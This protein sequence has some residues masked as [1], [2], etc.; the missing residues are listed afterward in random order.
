[1]SQEKVTQADHIDN[2]SAAMSTP[3]DNGSLNAADSL[4]HEGNVVYWKSFSFLGSLCAIMLMANSLFIGYS[5]PVNVLSVI[6]ADIGPSPNIYLVSMTF[7]LVSGVMLLIVGRLS[8][9]VGRR[10]FMM[11]AQV[12]SLVGSIIS[13]RANTVNVVIG[14]TVLSAFAGGAQQLYPMLVQELV[15]NKYRFYSQA[16]ITLSI[17]PTI[18]FGTAIARAFVAN[19]H[20]G[21]RWCY[22]LNVIV[23]GLSIVLLALCYFP[24]SFHMINKEMTTLQELRQ[25][26]YGG[27][28]LYSAGLVLLLLGFTW[29]EGTYPWSSAHVIAPIVVGAVLVAVFF[30]YQVYMPLKQPLM[31]IRLLKIRNF[32]AVVIVGC[33]GQMVY[34]ALNL[35][36][37]TIITTFLTTDNIKI[38]LMSSTT[39]AG[40]AVGE[41]I[42]APFFKMLGHP[43]YQLV[44]W[45]ILLT[46]LTALMAL[47]DQ[48]GQTLSLILT[49]LAGLCVGVVECITIVISGLVVPPEDIGASQGFYTS[50]RAV[51]GTIALSIYVS[52]YSAR[53]PVFIDR[54]VTAAATNAGLPASSLPDVFTALNNGTTAAL[55]A[56]PGMNS[57]IAQAVTDGN[58]LGYHQAFKL[59]FLSTIAFGGIAIIASFFVQDVSMYLNNFVNKTI[60]RPGNEGQAQRGGE[61]V[62]EEV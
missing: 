54:D 17:L 40:L 41:V 33:V 48:N 36:W 2:T 19:E 4:D 45:S 49:T 6:D 26:D 58:L 11:F 62:V 32:S 44:A 38:G 28:F 1:M 14:G 59:V 23:S 7:T 24:P 20:M 52:V 22:Y 25:L 5:M 60:H 10:Y 51:T 50:M 43:N 55:D 18:G 12:L 61:K 56:V 29:G 9:I 27:L 8:D 21:W 34:Y 46:V 57:T 35:L 42:I 53:L 47:V 16:A 39:G 37:P 3:V 30:L 15:P 31:P 13:A